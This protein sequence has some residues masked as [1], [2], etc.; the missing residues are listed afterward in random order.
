MQCPD[1]ELAEQWKSGNLSAFEAIFRRYERRVFNMAARMTGNRDDAEDIKQEAFIK[2]HKAIGSFRGGKFSTWLFKIAANLCL[3]RARRKMNKITSSEG[4][5]EQVDWRN[6]EDDTDPEYVL[7]REE[8]SR[9]VRT[10]LATIPPHYRILLV[11]RHIDDM[12]YEEI[13]E[14]I[15]C[16]VNALGVRLH[17]AREV[18]RERIKPFL[19]HDGGS[20]EDEMQKSK[21]TDIP[22]L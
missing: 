12:S 11:L 6:A 16:S 3:D 4:L 1:E 2:A 17:R 10:V 9:A 22:A 8:F 7:L 21:T 14:V 5:V 19:E 15:G 20:A 18:F 13:A